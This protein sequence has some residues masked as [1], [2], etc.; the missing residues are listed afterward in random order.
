MANLL[1]HPV[2]AEVETLDQIVKHYFKKDYTY[3]EII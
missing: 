1:S 2:L 3:L